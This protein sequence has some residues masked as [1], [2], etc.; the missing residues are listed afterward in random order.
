VLRRQAEQATANDAQAQAALDQAKL[1]LSYTKIY[2]TSAG[3]GRQQ[4]RAGRQLRAAWPDIVFGSADRS[5]CHR[6][7]QGNAADTHAHR[8][9]VSIDVDAFP[10]HML[11]SHVDSFQ[12]GTGLNF[13]LLPPENATGNFVKIVQRVPV[14]IMLDNADQNPDCSAPAF[15]SR[16]LSRCALRR[17][18]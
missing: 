12:H 2:A 8:S 1:N 11:H 18:G 17:T 5:L 14:K 6:Q 13:A 16:R 4:E 15:R 10:N 7:F 3:T 9:T